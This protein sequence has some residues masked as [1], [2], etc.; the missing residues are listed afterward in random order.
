MLWGSR[1][2]KTVDFG[3]FDSYSSGEAAPSGDYAYKFPRYYLVINL[4]Q[5]QIEGKIEMEIW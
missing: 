4:I 5:R 1:R 3:S 2:S